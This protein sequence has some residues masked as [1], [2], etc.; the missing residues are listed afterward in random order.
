M[1][2]LQE[3][4]EKVTSS[5][6]FNI[7]DERF[8]KKMEI[9][10][11]VRQGDVYIHSVEAN[12]KHGEVAKNN[13]LAIGN[14]K[15]SRHYAE[16]PAKVYEGNTLPSW[17]NNSFMGP[18]VVS[19]HRFTVSHPEHANISLPAGTYQITHQLDARTLERVKD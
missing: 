6:Q 9:G 1:Y 14:S 7:E 12:H 11:V 2:N 10:Q 8:I 17:C 15:G 13:Q 3:T 18:C 4:I 16:S 5:A 19:D